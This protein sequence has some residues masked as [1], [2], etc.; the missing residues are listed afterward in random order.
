MTSARLNVYHI[1]IIFRLSWAKRIH[2]WDLWK[3]WLNHR[4]NKKLKEMKTMSG[5]NAKGTVQIKKTRDKS[6]SCLKEFWKKVQL[7]KICPKLEGRRP[8]WKNAIILMLVMGPTVYVYMFT[9]IWTD[10]PIYI[11]LTLQISW[12]FF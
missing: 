4:I 9:I 2:T 8:D 6:W 10:W 3:D 1:I 11:F 5:L 12:L 7:K